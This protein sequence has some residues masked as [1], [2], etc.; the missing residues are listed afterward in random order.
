MLWERGETS[1][2]PATNG[3]SA[4]TGGTY[5]RVYPRHA[6]ALCIPLHSLYILRSRSALDSSDVLR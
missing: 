3:A 6:P 4:E 1:L 5:L 2:L